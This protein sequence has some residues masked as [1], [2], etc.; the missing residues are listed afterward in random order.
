MKTR[1]KLHAGGAIFA[2]A[3]LCALAAG[4]AAAQSPCENVPT[5]QGPVTGAFDEKSQVC[6]FLGVPY[7][8][9]PLGERRFALP[10]EHEPT[11]EESIAARV[12]NVKFAQAMMMPPAPQEPRSQ[13]PARS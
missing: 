9:P 6:A 7:A 10:E 2:S 5:K 1:I 8:A 13:V 11:P 4:A 3:L 12:R